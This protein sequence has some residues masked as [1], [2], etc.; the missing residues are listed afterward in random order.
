MIWRL[1][2]SDL[3]LLVQS[4]FIHVPLLF[5]PSVDREIRTPRNPATLIQV[6][7]KHFVRAVSVRSLLESYPTIQPESYQEL[8]VACL[9]ESAAVRRLGQMLGDGKL[10]TILFHILPH[11][12][13]GHRGLERNTLGEGEILD[14]IERK[15]SVP[16]ECFEE[17]GKFLDT[18][19]LRG[20][21]A[22]LEE[23]QAT[24]EPAHEGLISA[25]ELREWIRKALERGILDEEKARL[26]QLLQQQAGS[27][28]GQKRHLA[29]LLHIAEKGS[30]EIDG[31]GFRRIRATAEYYV[32]RHTGEYALRDSYGRIYLFPDCR[33]AVATS[34][35]FKPVVIEHYKHPF[36]EGHDSEQEIC[37]RESSPASA[38]T[39]EA[40]ISALEEGMSALL[41]GYSSRRRNGYHS[42][43]GMPNRV[44]S[45]GFADSPIVG[46]ADYPIIRNGHILDVDFE[47]CR[48]PR[49]HPK[50]ASGQVAI[51]NDLTP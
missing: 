14:A 38:F 37:L 17:A 33:V 9:Q 12:I 41:Y 22:G 10:R 31:F 5:D 50:V 51:T 29:V 48:V 24:P 6:N 18:Q 47:D 23:Q 28:E 2:D 45:L 36:L 43:E 19:A 11:F 21:L 16:P 27:V 44:G 42:L 49:A 8:R 30:L 3:E 32:Y 26:R 7:G 46:P 35:P 15:I 25:R 1:L 39:A 20:I 4:G 40:V 13:R 34:G